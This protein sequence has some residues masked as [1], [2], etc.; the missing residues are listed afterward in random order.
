MLFAK[1]DIPAAYSQDLV[2]EASSSLFMTISLPVGIYPAPSIFQRIM[3]YIRYTKAC[4]WGRSIFTVVDFLVTGSTLTEHLNN[5]DRV[6]TIR[7]KAGL[8]LAVLG[9]ENHSL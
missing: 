8:V 6:I 5:L 7:S 1:H 4:A 9:K 3:G 2:E